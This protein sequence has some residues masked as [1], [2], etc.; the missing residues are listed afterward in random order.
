MLLLC[1]ALAALLRPNG[2]LPRVATP[3]VMQVGMSGGD[4]EGGNDQE[5]NAQVAAL[6]SLFYEENSAEGFTRPESAKSSADLGLHRD[7]PI[8]RFMSVVLPHRQTAFN[9]FQPQLVHLFE[10]LLST[11]E[12]WIYMHTV[13]PGGA[14]NLGN[15]EEFALPGLGDGGA[16]GSRCEW[17]LDAGS[18]PGETTA[19]LQGTLMQVVS[20]QRQ[21]DARLALIVQGLS[22]AVVLR[23]KQAL[24]YARGDVQILPDSEQLRAA[25]RVSRRRHRLLSSSPLAA[26]QLEGSWLH[27]AVIAAAAAEERSWRSYEFSPVPIQSWPNQPALA[28]LAPAEAG[29][30]AALAAGS[31]AAAS[32]A[33]PPN[34]FEAGEPFAGCEI[35]Q[36]AMSG[37]ESWAEEFEVAGYP[38]LTEEAEAAAEAAAARELSALEVQTWLELDAFLRAVAIQKGDGN[39]PIPAQVLS[40]LPPPPAARGWPDEFVLARIADGIQ[41][42][43]DPLELAFND[44]DPYVPCSELYDARRRTQRISFAIWLM[45]SA[46]GNR[47]LQRVLEVPSTSDRLRLAVLRLRELRGQ[48]KG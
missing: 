15:L 29:R 28:T 21:P 39:L 46:G 9:I 5:R 24:P 38:E 13:L 27:S 11:P 42:S 40:L 1:T 20:Y 32:D 37:V 19:T 3:A 33:L 12:P 2:R 47:E 8:A 31:A 6:K 7:I 4:L 35:G 25:A 36:I 48:L 26:P 43:R 34:D 23:G 10:T 18:A 22:R 30:C 44:R 45:I 16:M 14:A 41:S 17:K